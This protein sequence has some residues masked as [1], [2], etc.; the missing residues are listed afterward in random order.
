MRPEQPDRVAP[1]A[2]PST[3]GPIDPELRVTPLSGQRGVRVTGE[4]NVLTRA[5]WVSALDRVTAT[6]TTGT[7]GDGD[8]HLELSELSFVDAGGAAALAACAQRL[9]EGRRMVLH[10]PPPALNRILEILWP[11]MSGVEVATR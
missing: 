7:A 1:Q 10:D 11:G 4:I 6:A 8:V 2:A 3:R 5:Q 9:G